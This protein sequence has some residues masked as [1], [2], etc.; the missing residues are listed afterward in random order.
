V[1]TRT[2]AD[3]VLCIGI[4][5]EMDITIGDAHYRLGGD[6][7]VLA[8]AHVPQAFVKVSSDDLCFYT[9]HF[10]ALV[11]G[12]L[13]MPSLYGLATRVSPPGHAG[14]SLKPLPDASWTSTR[15]PNPAVRWRPR[16][17]A[18]ACCHSR[19]TIQ[20]GRSLR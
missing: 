2:I 17:S 3:H 19:P 12:V 18:R 16:A 7:I 15:G 9:V 14:L 5:G 11:Y 6:S 8:P 4:A 20:L 10:M 13:D 1:P